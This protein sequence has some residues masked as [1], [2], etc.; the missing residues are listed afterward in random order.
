MG[1]A[2]LDVTAAELDDLLRGEERLVLVDFWNAGCEP[3]RELRPQ[4]EELAVRHPDVCVVAAVEAGAE[5]EA[6]ERH[7]VRELPTLVFFKRGRE[8]HRFKGG[9]LP[10]STLGLLV[11]ESAG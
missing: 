4:L 5:R 9:A 8:V 7:G 11:D 10:A 2:V 1:S 3:C 6:V